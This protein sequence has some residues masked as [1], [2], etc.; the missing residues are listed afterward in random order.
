MIP[1]N[2]MV[3]KEQA[4]LFFNAG[5][6]T[7]HSCLTIFTGGLAP[8]LQPRS[9]AL[10]NGSLKPLVAHLAHHKCRPCHQP[11]G[12]SYCFKCFHTVPSCCW[13]ECQGSPNAAKPAM[14]N[15]REALIQRHLETLI[16]STRNLHN[17]HMAPAAFT[18]SITNAMPFRLM[19]MVNAIA[20]ALPT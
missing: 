19:F 4:W 3:S 10:R 9:L 14:H 13:G 12:L 17:T 20:R 2:K 18:N 15:E 7:P 5:E 1:N 8:R 16:Y 11:N 6:N